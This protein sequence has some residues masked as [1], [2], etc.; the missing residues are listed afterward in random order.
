M[1]EQQ[2]AEFKKITEEMY[3]L[4]V[5][6]NNDYGADNISALGE[7]AVFVR[8]FDKICRMRSLLWDNKDQKVND[9]TLDDTIMDISVYATILLILRRGKWGK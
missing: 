5:R 6:K 2:F 7:K 8:M 3:D 4:H 1:P 9:E